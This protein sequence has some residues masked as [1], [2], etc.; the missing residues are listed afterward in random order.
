M[1]IEKLKNYLKEE[2]W[3]RST[4]EKYN[5]NEFKQIDSFIDEIKSSKP[6]DINEIYEITKSFVTHNP[7]TIVGLYILGNLSYFLERKENYDS[8]IR[9]IEIFKENK[10]INI[11]EF[12]LKKILSYDKNN[13]NALKLLISIYQQESSD[14]KE[15]RIKY[16]ED[17]VKA[18][19]ND[20]ETPFKLAKY[21]EN[22]AKDEKNPE[23]K[24]EYENKAL[25]Y[26]KTSLRRFAK[27]SNPKITEIW[28]TLTYELLDNEKQSKEIKKEKKLEIN[29]FL[30]IA[31]IIAENNKDTAIIL[32]SE[33]LSLYHQEAL[34]SKDNS[35]L[36]LNRCIFLAKKI[37][38]LDP[39]NRKVKDKI[40]EIYKE[41]YKNVPNIDKYI[42]NSGLND[43]KV[44]I[45]TAIRRFE[46]EIQFMICNYVYHRTWGI[47]KILKVEDEC[48]TITFDDK[49][50]HKMTYSMAL[51]SLIPLSD[52]HIW[53]LK[54][55]NKIGK[56]VWEDTLNEEVTKNILTVIRS[57]LGSFQDRNVT[58]DD[59]KNE[60]IPVIQSQFP[61]KVNGKETIWNN[62]WNKVKNIIKTDKLIGSNKEGR[63]SY[64]LR[65]TEISNEDE[66]IALFNENKNFI[67]KF[68]VFDEFYKDKYY[69]DYSDNFKDMVN[70]FYN[71]AHD[72]RY[73]TYERLISYAVLRIISSDKDANW[74]IDMPINFDTGLLNDIEKVAET[75][76]MS[77]R[78]EYKKE[79][80]RIITD[81]L[82]ENKEDYLIEILKRDPAKIIDL[83]LDEIKY[84]YSNYEPSKIQDKIN[85]IIIELATTS[86]KYNPYV[87][88]WAV[89]YLME[90]DLY[91]KHQISLDSVYLELLYRMDTLAKLSSQKKL[92]WF[93][94]TLT[95][96]NVKDLI[97]F[98]DS[99]LFLTKKFNFKDFIMSK[100]VIEN[101]N[102]VEKIY[103]LLRD[104]M[105]YDSKDRK[106]IIE[107]LKIKY[108]DLEKTSSE[109]EEIV[110]NYL[111]EKVI[112]T[113]QEGLEKQKNKLKALKLEK[114]KLAEELQK[115]RDKGDLRENAEYQ[116]AREKERN[117]NAE[118][119]QLEEKINR[120]RIIN[121]SS[122]KGDRV[123]PGTKVLIEKGGKK[124]E[125]KI[126]GFW[127]TDESKNIIA[128]NAPISKAIIGLK[129]GE[130]VE[131]IIGGE[132][133][134][135]K[136]LNIEP[137]KG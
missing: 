15:E 7:K 115:A 65:E 130:S 51:K 11:A 126:L 25:S 98:G 6:E 94:I 103:R 23:L 88:F 106:K 28:N 91:L 21:F 73:Y 125:Y 127:D 135:I 2:Q 71:I 133:T 27:T 35:D 55:E 46:K 30:N 49:K 76:Q 92:N 116:A 90:K 58:V 45:L 97:K 117:I 53:V 12:L 64:F 52:S 16:M 79:I 134:L 104:L 85:D 70:Y 57:I 47:G 112:W 119:T 14:K 60:L 68:K 17:L 82:T 129:K 29:F 123:I 19:I 95:P 80:L 20:G 1:V 54:K 101:K 69:I 48:F 108:P 59:F 84:M 136:V 99:I 26:Y 74:A 41:K 83:V 63:L 4:I 78:S 120:S 10:R 121:L 81:Y 33:L 107:E 40:I 3:T 96:A 128:Y 56:I 114:E 100:E 75:L 9:L 77:Y 62:W 86:F 44:E 110:I 5:E 66:L 105:E 87:N 93:N 124:E 61:K 50:E 113:T 39:I 43:K 8:F 34:N 137:I 131:A 122:L 111:D 89:K 13:V 18:D 42:G 24:K 72:S 37:L 118:I 132:K 32:L 31:S 38:E 67:D 102:Y 36:F 22:A 109:E